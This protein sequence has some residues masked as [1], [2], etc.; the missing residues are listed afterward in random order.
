MG[1]KTTTDGWDTHFNMIKPTLA[2][3]VDDK[4]ES[5]EDLA[6]ETTAS[7][8]R[9]GWFT[10]SN[11]NTNA[12]TAASNSWYPSASSNTAY[13]QNSW[14]A[15]SY[16]ATTTN[17]P[18]GMSMMIVGLIGAALSESTV[19]L[20]IMKPLAKMFHNDINVPPMVTSG[21]GAS[22]AAF[23]IAACELNG[24]NDNF[25]PIEILM[26]PMEFASEGFDACREL[27]TLLGLLGDNNPANGR[28]GNHNGHDT[29]HYGILDD[30]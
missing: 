5:A 18:L 10:N 9:L 15:R 28:Q 14:V 8:R 21:L 4:D 30:N 12:N 17:R 29:E 1:M 26:C 11:S 23:E 22:N 20:R 25:N 3:E 13:T 24:V 19:L 6:G 27:F 2:G 16:G 7:E